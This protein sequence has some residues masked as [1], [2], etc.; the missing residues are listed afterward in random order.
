MWGSKDPGPLP[1]NFEGPPC[2][3]SGEMGESARVT[4][5]VG[6]WRKSPVRASI[7]KK[8]RT[9]LRPMGVRASAHGGTGTRARPTLAHPRTSSLPVP[10]RRARRGKRASTPR[11]GYP[12]PRLKGPSPPV[13][14]AA[15]PEPKRASGRVAEARPLQRGH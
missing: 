14:D 1:Q 3:E 7:G 6:G 2:K 12:Q 10:A 4:S 11:T 9:M 5:Q 8:M 13:A 15:G